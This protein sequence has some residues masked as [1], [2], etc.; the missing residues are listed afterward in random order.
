MLEELIAREGLFHGADSNDE[1][2]FIICSRIP[3]IIVGFSGA[4]FEVRRLR[5]W[6]G[7]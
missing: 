4:H 3:N 6:P 1:R 2:M 7:D 5:S